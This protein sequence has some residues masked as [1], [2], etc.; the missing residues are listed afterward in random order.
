MK[1]MTNGSKSYPEV[2]SMNI[3]RSYMIIMGFV[4]L[5]LW[6]SLPAQAQWWQDKGLKE[7]FAVSETQAKE[8]DAIFDSFQSKRKDL[9]NES[10]NLQKG[11]TSLLEQEQL[12][13]EAVDKSVKALEAVRNKLFSE[14]VDARLSIRKILGPDQIKKII[15]EN[16]KLLSSEGQRPLRPLPRIEPRPGAGLIP[17]KMGPK[18]N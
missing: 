2:F 13:K 6:S 18:Q 9:A 14:T 11:L 8:M 7:K 15:A 16:P 17:Q 1:Y 10:R 5:L 3:R 12:D 4:A